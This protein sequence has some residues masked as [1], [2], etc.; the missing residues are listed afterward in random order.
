MIELANAF[1]HFLFLM[2]A[3]HALADRPLQEGAIRVDKYAPRGVPGDIRWLYGLWCH[4]LIHGGFVA[5][6]TGQWWLGAAETL[7]H[8]AIDDAKMRG[9]FGQIADQVLHLACKC[10]WA[11]IAVAA[12]A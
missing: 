4:A 8:A 10:A 5:V 9:H 2:A 1:C 3:G 6:I 11:A 7:S 12:Q